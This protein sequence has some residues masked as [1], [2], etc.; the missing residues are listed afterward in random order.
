MGIRID[1]AEFTRSHMRQPKGHGCW[2]FRFDAENDN[3]FTPHAMS[4]TD[5]KAA[6]R[7]EAIVRRAQVV[8]VLP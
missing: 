4:F 3:W 6:A 2:A 5:A 8:H 7:R 1:T